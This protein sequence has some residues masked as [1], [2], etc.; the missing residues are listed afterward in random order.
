MDLWKYRI[1]FSWFSTRISFILVSLIRDTKSM[2]M[3]FKS[4]LAVFRYYN[5]TFS[6]DFCDFIFTESRRN[7][8]A[9]CN[10]IKEKFHLSVNEQDFSLI[11]RS[12]FKCFIINCNIEF[13]N[14]K[15][16]CFKVSIKQEHM[17]CFQGIIRFSVN[18][19]FNIYVLLK[20]K[21]F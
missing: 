21:I 15:L 12:F 6:F 18:F 16:N 5:E 10:S 9:F 17:I 1:Y 2:S 13:L 7:F 8:I 20:S 19:S 3:S 14:W 11:W 4:F